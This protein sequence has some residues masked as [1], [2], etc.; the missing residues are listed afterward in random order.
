M[1]ISIDLDSHSGR[2][3]LI[4]QIAQTENVKRKALSLRQTEVYGDYL[5]NHVWEN[6]AGRFS[7]ETARQM[8]ICAHI[9]LAR[10]IVKAEASIYLDEPLRSFTE[11][12]DDQ[13]EKLLLIYR[14]MLANQKFMRSNE[15]FKLQQQNHI[16]IVPRDGKLEMRVLKNHHVDKI[17]DDTNP[18]VAAGYVINNFDRTFFTDNRRRDNDA[19]RSGKFNQFTNQRNDGI[20]AVIGDEDDWKSSSARYLVWTKE[21][22][23]I[24]NGKGVIVSEFNESPIPGT[25]PIIDI[26]QE[27]DFKYWVNQGDAIVDATIDHNVTMSDIGFISQQSGFGQA[28]MITEEGAQSPENLQVGPNTVIR[29]EVGTGSDFKPEF[30]YAQPGSDLMGS[31]EYANAKLIGFLTSRGLDPDVVTTENKGGA[32]NSGVQEFLRMMK[33][34]KATKEDYSTF[35][36]T[37]MKAYEVIKAWLSEAPELINKKY[38]TGVLSEDSELMIQFA[39]PEMLQTEQEKVDVWQSKIDMGIASRI[40]ALMAIEGL[41]RESAEERL[42]DIDTDDING[43]QNFGITDNKENQVKL[44]GDDSDT[45]DES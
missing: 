24:M 18:E 22:N 30:G 7:Q 8:P 16:M 23:Y 31:L 6:I 14:D 42:E 15:S 4:E 11:V 29:M 37:E 32:S 36:N 25:I 20:D 21:Y 26:S 19:N 12:S 2:K 34:F 10:R 3:L 1:A 39:G 45:E 44:E 40:D 43:N 13:E 41:T 35:E 17:D 5:F 9:N 33:H 27:K 38:H 28:Y